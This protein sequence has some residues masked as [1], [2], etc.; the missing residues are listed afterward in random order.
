[1]FTRLLMKI[2]KSVVN[3]VMGQL[4]QQMNIISDLVRAPMQGMINEVTGG[5]WVGQGADAFVNELTNLFIPGSEQL[6]GSVDLIGKSI[7]RALDIMD[8]ADKKA[9]GIVDDLAGVFS[10]IL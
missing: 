1:M 3:E 7:N 2:A 5:V 8:D 10:S 9:K 6:H 4:T